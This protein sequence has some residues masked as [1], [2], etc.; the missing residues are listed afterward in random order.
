MAHDG[1]V[2]TQTMENYMASETDL[3]KDLSALRADIGTLTETV[4]K[5][6]SVAAG[7]TVKRGAKNAAGVGEEMWDEVVHL[8][9]DTADA[10]RDAGRAGMSSLENEIKRNPLRA[11]LV[12]L[13]VGVIVGMFGK[14]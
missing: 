2:V 7:K 6:V 9:H 5:L 1:V 11:V 14:K 13:C 3:Q 8:G 4:G 10:A 12:V